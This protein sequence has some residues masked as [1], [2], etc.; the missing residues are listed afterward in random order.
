MPGAE[1]CW[2]IQALWDAAEADD[3]DRAYAISGPLSALVS[4]Q[5]TIDVFVAVEKYLLHKQGVL[6]SLAA[7]G[8]SG[9]VMD[10]ETASEVDRLFD[11]ITGGGAGQF[12]G[13]PRATGSP[14]GRA[15]APCEY[16]AIVRATTPRIAQLGRGEARSHGGDRVASRVRIG[17]RDAHDAV[18]VLLVI[19][20]IR[21]GS[22]SMLTRNSASVVMV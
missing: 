20:R 17:H 4:M 11:R 19:Q 21:A 16:F 8:P 2:A 5:T 12:P 7:R 9:F 22:A 13:P 6:D 14:T 10:P 1:V 3:W 18:A 15:T